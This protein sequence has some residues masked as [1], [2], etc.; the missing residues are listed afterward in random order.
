ME[1]TIYHNP[2]C[3]KSREALVLLEEKKCD[4]KIVEYLKDTLSLDSLSSLIDELQI[5]PIELVRR[6][7]AIWKEGFKNRELSDKE[8]IKAMVENPKLIERPIVISK[9]GV[10]IG[11]P[12]ENVM[13]VI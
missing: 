12:L 13:E 7:E 5:Q 1:V 3:R 8:I 9:K 4:I 11:R 10:V 6:N 2:R